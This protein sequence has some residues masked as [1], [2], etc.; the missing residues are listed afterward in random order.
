MKFIKTSFA[1]AAIAGALLAA[2]AQA[3]VLYMDDFDGNSP[4]FTT[5][6][7]AVAPGP[8][9]GLP[10][11]VEIITNNP[12]SVHPYWA[13]F[14]NGTGKALIVNG[15]TASVPNN[16]FT[17][18][19]VAVSTSGSYSFG[20][21]VA[22]ICC[23]SSYFPNASAASKLLFAFIVNGVE[24]PTATTFLTLPGPVGGN[25]PNAGTF[26]D[27]TAA[28]NLTA[29]DMFQ[30]IIRNDINAAGGN[31]FALDNIVLENTRTAIPEPLTLSLFGAGLAAATALRRR[32]KMQKA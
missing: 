15:S 18:A 6:Y 19:A 28:I 1:I 32:K 26:F 30:V 13:A 24:K 5:D 8:N 3:A 9:A 25:Y 14:T 27:V 20:A 12:N 22:N 17:S 7:T 21:S 31:D 4:S 29:G 10:E 2:P 16:V 23:N 11:G